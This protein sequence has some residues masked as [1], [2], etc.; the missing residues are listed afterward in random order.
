M[1]G[2]F[3]KQPKP[4]LELYLFGA[5]ANTGVPHVSMSLCVRKTILNRIKY[6][7]LCFFFPV[8]I[9]SW[10]KEIEKDTP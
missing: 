6:W 1:N 5:D 3:I 10:D 9:N 7:F 2:A 4:N 8:K